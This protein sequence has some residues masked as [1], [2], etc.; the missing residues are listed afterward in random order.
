VADD[1]ISR[2]QSNETAGFFEVLR[3][4]AVFTAEPRP[5]RES[6]REI[7]RSPIFGTVWSILHMF[8]ARGLATAVG[9]SSAGRGAAR[10]E[11]GLLAIA[12]V[13]PAA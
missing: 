5:T 12:S 1:T 7:V 11:G 9:R 4:I 8:Q 6:F 13:G 2:T 10:T 3:G